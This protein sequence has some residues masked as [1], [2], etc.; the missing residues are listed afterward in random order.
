MYYNGV[1]MYQKTNVETADPKKLV[2]MCY[3]GAIINLKMAKERYIEK[4]FE[5]KASALSKAMLII[6]ELNSALDSEK[7]GEIALNLKAIY[8][9]I[10]RRLTEGDMHGE[11]AAFDEAI[12]CLESWPWHGKK[13]FM[14]KT[15]QRPCTK[16]CLTGKKSPQH[17][18]VHDNFMFC[19]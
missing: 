2:V 16:P 13:F 14:E 10:L 12:S 8:E 1:S 15:K 5:A 9:Y 7:G 18:S 17:L 6:G 4:K 11:L 19:L 3:D